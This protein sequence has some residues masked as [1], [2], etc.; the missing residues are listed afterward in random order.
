MLPCTP[1]Q[2][3]CA[4]ACV[5]GFAFFVARSRP[6]L[7]A[8]PSQKRSTQIAL[9]CSQGNPVAFLLRVEKL[10]ENRFNLPLVPVFLDGRHFHGYQL[11]PKSKVERKTL[12]TCAIE[13]WFK[14]SLALG[15]NRA[16]AMCV[17][18]STII[19]IKYNLVFVIYLSYCFIRFIIVVSGIIVL[20]ITC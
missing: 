11:Y 4:R 9:Q 15:S 18:S 17:S 6:N 14:W 3:V 8:H 2:K 12:V 7:A 10:S 16:F 1:R 5:S 19:I 13:T 20:P